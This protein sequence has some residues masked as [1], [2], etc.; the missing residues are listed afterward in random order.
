MNFRDTYTGF[1]MCEM[2]GKLHMICNALTS[3]IM[4]VCVYYHSGNSILF[5]ATQN[6]G[7]IS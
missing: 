2:I 7:Y 4:C 5:I 6:D 3:H 1:F